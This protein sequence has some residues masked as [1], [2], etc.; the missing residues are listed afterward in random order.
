[1][2]TDADWRLGEA[3]DPGL[4][5]WKDDRLCAWLVLSFLRFFS[6]S[7]LI[8]RPLRDSSSGVSADQASP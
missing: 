2:T 1:M 6:G 3:D 7:L 4:V 8:S 5:S